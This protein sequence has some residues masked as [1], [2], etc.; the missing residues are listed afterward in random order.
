MQTL[1][2]LFDAIHIMLRLCR[3]RVMLLRNTALR[4]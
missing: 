3:F 2:N 1:Q 4:I